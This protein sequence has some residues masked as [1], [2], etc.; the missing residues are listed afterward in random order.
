MLTHQ[1][2]LLADHAALAGYQ[3]AGIG[4]AFK[5]AG[6][7][8]LI[9]LVLIFAAGAVIG[10]LIGFFIGRAVGRKSGAP[11]QGDLAHDPS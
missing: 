10:L 8:I 3:A 4:S 9:F 7:A 1:A 2:L 5:A 6:K 11:A